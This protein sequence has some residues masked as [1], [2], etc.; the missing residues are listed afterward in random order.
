MALLSLV[1]FWV[2]V[3]RV[4]LARPPTYEVAGRALDG[5]GRVELHREVQENA[6]PPDHPDVLPALPPPVVKPAV[7]P[8]V[9]VDAGHGGADGGTVGNGLLEKDW[10]LKVGLALAEELKQRG[11]K[12][13]LTRETDV[14]LPLV[15]RPA[16]V[17]AA[18][19][20]ALISVHF[21]AGT[22]DAAGVETWYSWPKK[23]EVMAQLHTA[24]GVPIA[25][26]LPDDGQQL[27]L[28]IQAAVSDR[29]G[30]RDRGIKNRSDLA[31]TSRTVCPAVLI[32]CGFLSNGSESRKIQ[33]AAYRKKLVTG[34][35]DGLE[36]WLRSRAAVPVGV[37]PSAVPAPAP[38]P[39]PAHTG[40]NEEH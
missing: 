20:I 40:G 11:H 10:T 18:P 38:A 4:D 17:N 2:C 9:M 31:M 6:E 23:P 39:L 36:H 22:P 8:V 7:E 3:A 25:G 21:N 26:T 16:L 29:T 27:A 15:D 32:E 1:G 33:D 12:V 35:A 28:A 34:I 14:T 5:N 30:A 37:S 19:R 24:E 13:A